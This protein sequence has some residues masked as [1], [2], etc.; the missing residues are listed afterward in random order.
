MNQAV[1]NL[2]LEYLAIPEN[3]SNINRINSQYSSNRHTQHQRQ[4]EYN[5]LE[6]ALD[7]IY[8]YNR[9]MANYQ[10]N[11]SDLT[12]LLE[13]MHQNYYRIHYPVESIDI[14]RNSVPL[15]YADISGYYSQTP[16][17]SDISRNSNPYIQRGNAGVQSNS[18]IE[19]VIRYYLF[20]SGTSGNL[21]NPAVGT[22]VR[23]DGT[24]RPVAQR[25]S[26][27]EIDYTTEQ[28]T[29]SLNGPSIIDVRCPISLDDFHEGDSLCKILG[30][31]HVF[32][33]SHLMDW[34]DRN[35]RCPVCR[36]NLL[37]YRRN[38]SSAP[39]PVI[40]NSINTIPNTS[41]FESTPLRDISANPFL[42]Q[43]LMNEYEN[44]NSL[45]Q[46]ELGSEETISRIVD[47]FNDFMLNPSTSRSYSIDSSGNSS[48]YQFEFTMY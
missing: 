27:I 21:W 7:L 35:T 14:S 33:H 6:G 25:L 12:R 45:I 34:L 26:P 44:M 43:N 46:N 36:Y 32:K 2:L 18:N 4:I 19:N 20:P 10:N 38:A 41:F 9:N 31:G 8:Y 37:E 48:H 39:A 1:Q 11:I 28:F 40:D 42:P 24:S 23:N 5:Q 16:Y 30:C 3:A 22:P 15:R 47:I 29:Y 17:T 13:T